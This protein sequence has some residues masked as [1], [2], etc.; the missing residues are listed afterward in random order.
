MFLQY[1]AYK[2]AKGRVLTAGLGLGMF[3]SMVARKDEVTEVVV[4]EID[5]DIIKLCKPQNKRI[6][7][8]HGDVKEFLKTTKEKF[9]YIYIDIH[10]STGAMEYI[11]TVL[12][13]KKVIEER[14]PGVPHDFWGEEE[15]KSQYIPGC[16]KM[17]ENA[18][19]E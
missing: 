12:P 8:R 7:V 5:K 14:F 11:E 17:F 18:Q 15:M 4:V 19:L 6:K 3:A 9:D 1:D 16:G 13:M 10:Y 2:R